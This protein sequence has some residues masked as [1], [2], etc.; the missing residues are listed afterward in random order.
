MCD[1]TYN[2]WPNRET[3]AFH[4]WIT[5]EQATD[6]AARLIVN[7]AYSCTDG[8]HNAGQFVAGEAL[9]AWWSDTLDAARD[10]GYHET[11]DAMRDDVGSLWRVDWQAVAA[12]LLDDDTDD[13]SGRTADTPRHP[14]RTESDA[15]ALDRIAH[16]LRDPEWGVGMFEDIADVVSDTGRTIQGTCASCGHIAY[17]GRDEQCEADGCVCPEHEQQA[18]WDRH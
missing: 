10:N 2:G 16:I 14:A 3:W 1:E 4:L 17:G 6:V 5:N 12:A 13:A 11:F 8:A 18:T 15:D 9:R 7:N